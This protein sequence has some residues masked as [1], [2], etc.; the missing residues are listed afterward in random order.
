M[1][2]KKQSAVVAARLNNSPSS[3]S[4]CVL[5]TFIQKTGRERKK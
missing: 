4:L 2:H 5:P 1:V 3:R